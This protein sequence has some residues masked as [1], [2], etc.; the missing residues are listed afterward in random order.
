VAAVLA[1]YE[2]G[3]SAELAAALGLSVPDA[4]R[5]LGLA[6]AHGRTVANGTVWKSLD[7]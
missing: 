7:R 5:F 1:A 4:E 2:T 6:G 3:T